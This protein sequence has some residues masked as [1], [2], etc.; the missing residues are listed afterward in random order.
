MHDLL[1]RCDGFRRPERIARLATVCEADKRGRAGLE[2]RS[3]PQAAELVR[4]RDAAALVTGADIAREG[5]EGPAF[6]EALRKARI[7][8]IAR[9]RAEARADAS[10]AIQASTGSALSPPDAGTSAPRS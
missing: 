6:G 1:A 10:N 2:E 4:L 3:Y 7:A 8:A 5:L 9:A